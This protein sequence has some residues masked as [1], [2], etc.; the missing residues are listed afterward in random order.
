VELEVLGIDIL[1]CLVARLRH[2]ELTHHADMELVR[3]LVV[4]ASAPLE[5]KHIAVLLDRDG[6]HDAD[7]RVERQASPADIR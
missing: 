5:Q 7:I 2:D 6:P 1:R 3:P 4:F